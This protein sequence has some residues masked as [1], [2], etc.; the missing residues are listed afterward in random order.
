MRGLY[1]DNIEEFKQL[2]IWM[3]EQ[4][5][6]TFTYGGC[7]VVFNQVLPPMAPVNLDYL[8]KLQEAEEFD[9]QQLETYSS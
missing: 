4:G 5:V 6:A 7:T 1:M 3:K 8:K 9:D 2:V